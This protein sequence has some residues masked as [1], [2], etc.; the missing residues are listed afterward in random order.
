M[1]QSLIMVTRGEDGNHGFRTRS[2]LRKAPAG[3]CGPVVLLRNF[4]AT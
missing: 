4:G 1:N 2:E 3:R